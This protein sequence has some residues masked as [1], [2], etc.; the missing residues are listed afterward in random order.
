[1]SNLTEV[2]EYAKLLHLGIPLSGDPKRKV[3]WYGVAS[4]QSTR[5][6]ILERA[7]VFL[8]GRA[9]MIRS[10]LSSIPICYL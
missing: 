10:C 5:L 2:I 6:K 4:K 7:L 8:K 3:L 1:M 9:A